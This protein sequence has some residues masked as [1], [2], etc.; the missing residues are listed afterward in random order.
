MSVGTFRPVSLKKD[1]W[2]RN[3]LLFLAVLMLPGAASA[4][5]A[6]AAR[7]RAGLPPEAA[8]IYDQAL[9]MVQPTTD[10][11]DAL[12]SKTRSLVMTGKVSRGTARESAEAAGACFQALRQ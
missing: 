6:E 2:M 11:R 10:I 12:R 8:L 1:V 7:C 3:L 5:T 4:G 9:P